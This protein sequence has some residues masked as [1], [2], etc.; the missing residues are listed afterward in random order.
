M[1]RDQTNTALSS[2]LSRVGDRWSLLIVAALLAGPLRFNEL[3]E[4]IPGIASNVLSERLKRL[5][6]EAVLV[7]RPYSRRPPRMTYELTS[8]GK[9]LASAV[10]LL[11]EW[12]AQGEGET[13]VLRHDA[14]GS[15][16]TLGWHCPNCGL[17]EEDETDEI[18][19]V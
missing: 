15:P 2:A 10:R 19:F 18:T 11:E 1:E 6:R 12:G 7:S 16:V 5:A 9:E 14:C 8:R 13:D 4:A 3:L 17:L